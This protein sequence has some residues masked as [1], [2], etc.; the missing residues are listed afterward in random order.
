M[1]QKGKRVFGSMKNK[2]TASELVEEREAGKGFDR[3]ELEVVFWRER[4]QVEY[5]DEESRLMAKHPEVYG[6]SHHYFDMTT[7]EI[8]QSWMKKLKF[9]YDNLDR[10]RYFGKISD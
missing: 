6:N 9:A 4:W 10:S 7:S 2:I 1:E 8:S 5:K 3:K